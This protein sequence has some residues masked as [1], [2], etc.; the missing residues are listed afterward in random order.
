[1]NLGS[2]TRALNPFCLHNLATAETF[3]DEVFA[4]ITLAPVHKREVLGLEEEKNDASTGILLLAEVISH[5]ESKPVDSAIIHSL[6][7]FFKDKLARE[8]VKIEHEKKLSALQSQEYKGEDE[9]KIFKTKTS[10]NRLQSLIVVTSQAVSTTSTTIIGL[11]D[12]DLVPQLVD[13][14]IG[15]FPITA[16]GSTTSKLPKLPYRDPEVMS[17]KSTPMKFH[18]HRSFHHWKYARVVLL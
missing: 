3:T 2:S 4:Q 5:I 11:R 1:M 8:G 9:A 13:L 12:S 17:A 16:R 6:V 14:C 15:S 10:I 7:G 18:D